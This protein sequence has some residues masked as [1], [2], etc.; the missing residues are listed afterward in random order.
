MDAM[1]ESP[2]NLNKR[3]FGIQR[4]YDDAPWGYSSSNEQS[5]KG[6]ITYLMLPMMG[7]ASKVSMKAS[8]AKHQ[9]L[10]RDIQTSGLRLGAVASLGGD[11][12]NYNRDYVVTT[13]DMNQMKNQEE[14]DYRAEEDCHLI[15]AA[16]HVATN[17]EEAKKKKTTTRMKPPQPT[18][19]KKQ[20]TAAVASIA[21]IP[22][23]VAS[24]STCGTI[25]RDENNNNN[26]NNNND[27]DNDNKWLKCERPYCEV[28]DKKTKGKRF[29]KQAMPCYDVE[30]DSQVKEGDDD[31]PHCDEDTEV[32]AL[33][34]REAEAVEED[35]DEDDDDD[36]DEPPTKKKRLSAID[37]IKTLY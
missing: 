9:T 4:S 32:E 8:E 12:V 30:E 22:S 33:M 18:I 34:C 28:I 21:T 27:N 16:K 19:L 24:T 36:F 1:N 20:S 15:N 6:L 13:L 5:L 14:E 23:S 26:N 17:N 11:D 7:L 10:A 29:R 3:S 25:R 31:W 37:L 2:F 35:E